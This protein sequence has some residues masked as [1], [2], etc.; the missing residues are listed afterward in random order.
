MFLDFGIIKLTPTVG[1]RYLNIRQNSW[2]EN[3]H[4]DPWD[5]LANAFDKK[6]DYF[7]K[8]PA[9]LKFNGLYKTG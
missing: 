7:L 3:L 9:L 8:A 6:S 1:L 2:F 4:G 5:L